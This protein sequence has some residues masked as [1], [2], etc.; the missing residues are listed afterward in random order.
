MRSA[1]LSIE[2]S[3]EL[4]LEEAVAQCSGA[5]DASVGVDLEA[6]PHQLLQTLELPQDLI[7]CFHIVDIL[8]V[9][10]LTLRLP[11]N[12]VPLP[13]QPPQRRRTRLVDHP[14]RETTRVLVDHHQVLAV[15]V[16]GE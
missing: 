14:L 1:R 12:D 8:P 16:G 3:N 5:V 15:G 6:L 11:L 10:Q 4:L 7:A 13:E 9:L 2:F